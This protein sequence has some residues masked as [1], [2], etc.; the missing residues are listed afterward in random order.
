M[1]WSAEFTKNLACP[2]KAGDGVLKA[3]QPVSNSP[4]LS[5]IKLECAQPTLDSLFC[6]E[7][8]QMAWLGGKAGDNYRTARFSISNGL[9]LGSPRMQGTRSPPDSEQSSLHRLLGPRQIGRTSGRKAQVQNPE[10]GGWTNGFHGIQRQHEHPEASG[11]SS[12]FVDT[13]ISET[14]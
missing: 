13:S 2:N 4:V 5:I 9:S 11:T 7:P 6:P 10:S 14:S 1:P 8:T 3:G 12:P